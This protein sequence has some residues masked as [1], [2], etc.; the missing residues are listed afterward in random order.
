LLSS[1]YSAGLIKATKPVRLQPTAL[2][3]RQNIVWPRG[4][5]KQKR[6]SSLLLKVV[7]LDASYEPKLW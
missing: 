3:G 5:R 7:K 2:K 4:I 1:R 6:R